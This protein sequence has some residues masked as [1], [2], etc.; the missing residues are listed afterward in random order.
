MVLGPGGPKALDVPLGEDD[1]VVQLGHAIARRSRCLVLLDN[2]RKVARHA[3]ETL[4]HWLDRAHE[5]AFVVTAREVLG[6]PGE[7]A[8]ALAPLAPRMGWRCSWPARARRSGTSGWTTGART[9][10]W[11]RCRTVCRWRSSWRRRGCG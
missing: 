3:E 2:F 5:A 9:R 8:F 6:L 11:C 1:P 7:S 4:A 10:R